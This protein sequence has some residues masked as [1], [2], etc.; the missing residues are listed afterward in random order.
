MKIAVLDAATLGADLDLSALNRESLGNGMCRIYPTS[1][2]AEVKE[3]IRDTE[4]IVINKIKIREDILQ[5]LQRAMI[6]LI[7]TLAEGTVWRSVMSRAIP[8]TALHS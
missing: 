8:R 7:S 5:S 2:D 1:T 3:R 4:V 6:I